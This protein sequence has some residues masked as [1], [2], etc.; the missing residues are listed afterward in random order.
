VIESIQLAREATYGAEP[1]RAA[2]LKRIN[3][4][5][6]SNGTGKTTISRVL[7]SPDAF[8]HCSLAWQDGAPLQVLAYNRQFVEENFHQDAKGAGQVKGIFTLGEAD[9]AAEARLADCVAARAPKV[10]R[11]EQ[12]ASEQKANAES[13]R[14]LVQKT[15]A[16]AY[17]HGAARRAGFGEVFR[18]AKQ[19][20]NFWDQLS[21][22]RKTNSGALAPLPDLERRAETLLKGATE[23]VAN[24]VV[25]DVTRLRVLE[26]AEILSTFLVA[27]GDVPLGALIGRLGHANWVREGKDLLAHTQ[28]ACPFCRQD[29]PDSLA[30]E[31]AAVFDDVY[32]RGVS[33]IRDLRSRYQE[34]AKALGA[35]LDSVDL[36]PG[37]FADSE[38]IKTLTARL[39]AELDVN[40]DRLGTKEREPNRSVSLVSLEDASDALAGLVA[41]ANLAIDRH[42]ALVDDHKAETQRLVRDVWRYVLDVD[43]KDLLGSYDGEYAAL[44][45]QGKTL[46]EEQEQLAKELKEL[47]GEIRALESKFTSIEPTVES[48]NRYLS[49]TGFLGFKLAP[50]ADRRHYSLQRED[51]KPAGDTLSEGEK[52]FVTFLYFFH[53]IKG[54]ASEGD[55]SLPRVVVIDDP[56]SSLDREILFVVSRLI[57]ELMD[58]LVP[59]GKKNGQPKGTVRQLIVLTHNV[60]FH[61]QVTHHIAL[62]GKEVRAEHVTYWMVRKSDGVSRIE[63]KDTNPVKSSYQLLWAELVQPD[64]A[65]LIRNTLR[66]ILESYF[67]EWGGVPLRE[68]SERFGEEDRL[69]CASLVDWVHEG[70]HWPDEFS[71]PVADSE[72]VERYLKVFEKIFEERGHRP[73][74]NMMMDMVRGTAQEG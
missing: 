39:R 71:A 30:Q 68:L 18:G 33:D 3:F 73:H 16:Q 48:I 5:F 50:A 36:A 46:A 51:G 47:A 65:L 63:V 20:G 72:T 74:Y 43:C 32:E 4:F 24:V 1:Q 34:E 9:R 55:T 52:S 17:R 64:N 61:R 59:G 21:K 29:V 22:Q 27:G 69:V 49:R 25:P 66:R 54:A 6:G 40:L 23:R 15:M 60:D 19:K 45:L 62:W 26:K 37:G 14:L 42:N 7:R 10:E 8:P 53:L 44:L 13:T 2:G 58:D 70:S 38:A 67:Q 31:L 11:L 41:D 57:R 12:L 56:V 28:G 35:Q